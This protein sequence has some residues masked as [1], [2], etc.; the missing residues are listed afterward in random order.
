M[1]T[2]HLAGDFPPER[3]SGRIVPS[4]RRIEPE[5][6]AIIN[7]AWSA[8][9]ADG[10]RL[11][12]DGPMARLES[13]KTSGGRIDLAFSE[14]S[15]KPFFGTNLCHPEL[16]DRFGRSV[17]ANAAGV[18]PAL[19]TADEFLLLGVRNS[20]VAYYPNRIHPFAGTMEPRDGADVFAA[21]R[22]EL[23][24]ELSLDPSD[25][26]DISL[27]GVAEDHNL[28]QDELIF[29]V[30]SHRTRAE[31]ESRLDQQEHRSVRAIQADETDISSAIADPLLTPVAVASL[32]LF[33]R[34]AFGVDWLRSTIGAS[35]RRGLRLHEGHE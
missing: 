4:S 32:L 26:R 10:S 5:V 15:Y 16:A 17:L 24:E 7:R 34:S 30:R 2:I 14:T 22:R 3:V 31:I 11:L 19:L 8:A 33:G 23:A 13:W 25:I 35:H 29:R 18:S 28:R 20:R 9:T 21:V 12:F 27:S 1:L 6:E